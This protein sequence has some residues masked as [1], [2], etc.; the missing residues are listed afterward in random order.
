MES[1]V[2]TSMNKIVRQIL[3]WL[4]PKNFQQ[5]SDVLL[6]FVENTKYR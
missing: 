1:E 3:E 4:S 5:K 2:Y 6:D